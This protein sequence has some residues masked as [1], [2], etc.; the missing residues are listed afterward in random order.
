M[1][2]PVWQKTPDWLCRISFLGGVESTVRL[3]IKSIKSKLMSWALSG[4]IPFW[5]CSFLFSDRSQENPKSNRNRIGIDTWVIFDFPGKCSYLPCSC[6]EIIG[7]I[8][9][10]EMTLNNK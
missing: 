5:V 6:H 1:V 10:I 3:G 2:R 7:R 9:S 4:V 8:I